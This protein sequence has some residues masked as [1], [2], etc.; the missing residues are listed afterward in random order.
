MDKALLEEREKFKKSFM[1]VHTDGPKS[2]K[3]PSEAAGGSGGSSSKKSKSDKESKNSSSAKAKLDLAQLK[4]MGAGGSQ[5]KF[6]VLTK[7]VRHM[8]TRHM[9]GEDQPLTLEEILD[10]THQ[11]DVDSKTKYWLST[12]AL[13]SNPKISHSLGPQGTTYLFKPPFS[14]LTKK[15]L[16]KLLKVYSIKGKGGIML[17]DLQESLP[18]CESIIRKL[19]DNG[20]IWIIP[21]PQDKKKVVYYHDDGDDFE[22]SEDF[23]KL[24]RSV[25]VDGKDDINIDEYLTKNGITSMQDQGNKNAPIKRKPIKRNIN[26]KKRAL[27]D[28]LHIAGD[29][30]DYSEMTASSYKKA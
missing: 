27:K 29:L 28:N 10:E 19:E 7:I 16:M 22:V 12:E 26:R 25:T 20:D 14:I 17:D 4:Q 13:K 11:L 21:R 8:K 18:K 3:R 9:E 15:A 6:G 5:F 2:G 23:V 1:K 24:W 30:E